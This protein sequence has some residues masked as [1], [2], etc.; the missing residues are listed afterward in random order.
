MVVGNTHRQKNGATYPIYRCPPINDCTRRVTISA[1]VAEQVVTNAV[2]A[3]LA[4]AEGRAS[5]S[6]ASL[7]A[8]NEL[9]AAQDALD[10]AV[11]SFGVAGLQDEPAAVERLA[12]LRSQR[13][14][15]QLRVDRRGSGHELVVTV[16]DWDRL[17]TDEHRSLIRAIV[18]RADVR[19]G[20]PADRYAGVEKRITVHL[21]SE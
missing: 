6:Q 9:R 14:D 7:D 19:P 10:A 2:K 17:T 4:D 1:T 21:V 8:A 18:A 16:D 3:V 5:A 13:D 15:A 12:E 11:R 20:S